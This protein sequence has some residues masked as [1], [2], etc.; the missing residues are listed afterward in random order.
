MS[1]ARGKTIP[2]HHY[3]AYIFVGLITAYALV[4]NWYQYRQTS[5]IMLD[6]AGDRIQLFAEQTSARVHSLYGPAL[7]FTEQLA[8]Q[9]LAQATSL[10]QR[11]DS[12]N[13]IV[14]GLQLNP[15]LASA[16]IGYPNGDFFLVRPLGESAALRNLLDPPGRTLWIVQSIEHEGDVARGEYLFFDAQLN[17]LARRLAPDYRYDPRTRPW[18]HAAQ[19]HDEINVGEPG[20]F[21]TT[22]EVG[23]TFSRASP[24]TGVV[25]A[26]DLSLQT[27]QKL[28]ERQRLT[29]HTQ[30]VLL[31][32]QDE[33]LSWRDQAP[34]LRTL[35]DGSQRLPLLPELIA[36]D[37]LQILQQQL[38]ADGTGMAEF[39]QEGLLW[40]GMAVKVPVPHAQPMRLWAGA[41]QAE[42][43]ADAVTIRNHT[44]FMALAFLAAGIAAAYLLSRFASRALDGLVTEADSIER[45]E[46]ARPVDVQTHITEIADLAR[47]M[48]SMKNTIRR[49]L[50]LS[51]ALANEQNFQNLLRRLLDEFKTVT[52]AHGGIVYL[53]E[54]SGGL[55]AAHADWH[56][57]C[58]WDISQL[59]S[60]D[61]PAK[62]VA[63]AALQ[64]L[65]NRKSL[66]A[67]QARELFGALMSEHNAF[68]LLTVPLRDRTGEL[69]GALAL[70]VD[71]SQH[72]LSPELIA[73]TEALSGTA[74]VALHTQRLIEEQKVLLESFIQVMAG[75]IDAKSA[76][77]GGHC[78][79]V[80]ELAKLLAQAACDSTAQPFADFKLSDSEWEELRIAAWLHDCGKVT[81]PEYIVDKATKLETLYDRIH[82]VRMRFEVLKRDAEI[83][84]WQALAAGGNTEL[85]SVELHA[86]WAELDAEFAFIAE[87]NTGGEFMSAEYMQRL[88]QISARTWR[89]TLSDRI[90]LSHEELARKSVV[91]E[92]DL[93][94]DELLLVDKPEH[95]FKREP[96]DRIAPDN[97]WGFKV[98]MPNYLYNRGELYNLQVARGTLS[99]EERYKINEHMIQTIKMLDQLPFP[100]HLQRVPEIAG[101]HH[102]KMDG[103]GYP[104]RLKAADMSTLARM[105]AVADI[106]EALTAVDRP[107]KKGKTLSEA[108]QIMSRMAREQHIDR[109]IFALFLRSGVYLDYARRFM[110]PEQID[111]VDVEAAL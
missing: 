94:C 16:Y 64:G 50:D 97:P 92:S 98:D 37:Q 69:L 84:Y 8:V 9:R 30:L 43:V 4:T 90:G 77:T 11:L 40:Q 10:A 96:R 42:L 106:F 41:P 53:V 49:F 6:T 27:L 14:T 91:L 45:F 35:P 108:V 23:V 95:I 22:Q 26:T 72:P 73:F 104:K 32:A 5:R 89:R 75:A 12:L 102:E 7:I 3:I 85:L 31:N 65:S 24:Q 60:F 105:M 79:R 18:Y 55:K 57:R 29:P 15:E 51:S 100:R 48:S 39:K 38:Q 88:Q 54:K 33:V 76:Y 70:F 62:I 74:A 80:P 52:G 82:E 87:C 13:Y 20:L 61:Q 107:Y 1:R 59:H 86:R 47:S 71:E 110:R 36:A 56:G 66:Q 2:L 63:A 58:D 21:F 81:M 44:M 78:Q 46:F 25:T 17:L 93:P 19:T 28:I 68:T 83:T 67:E 101:G 99:A 109:D 34:T 111:K 103:T